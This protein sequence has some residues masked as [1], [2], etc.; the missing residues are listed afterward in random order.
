MNYSFRHV[1]KSAG[2]A[3]SARPAGGRPRTGRHE[4]AGRHPDLAGH[5]PIRCSQSRSRHS[6]TTG[7]PGQMT[8]AAASQTLDSD[9]LIC[10]NRPAAGRPAGRDLAWAVTGLFHDDPLAATFSSCRTGSGCAMGALA[11]R[12]AGARLPRLVPGR[13]FD[14]F[15]NGSWPGAP[16]RN[17]TVGLLLTIWRHKGRC[18]SLAQVSG[19]YRIVRT[20][21]SVGA[22]AA[23]LCCTAFGAFERETTGLQVRPACPML[24]R[25]RAIVDSSRRTYQDCLDG[26]RTHSG[27]VAAA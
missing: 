11:A 16:L 14:T 27:H 17:R 8:P 25:A 22:V 24:S 19:S 15:E 20:M 1:R 7:L 6:L 3:P 4:P 21:V 13:P 23:H 5:L 10:L 9:A 18:R 12:G 2:A 26:L